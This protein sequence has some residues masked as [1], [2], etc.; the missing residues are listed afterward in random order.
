MA[1]DMDIV[2]LNF[3]TI[4]EQLTNSGLDLPVN[5]VTQMLECVQP[6][7]HI[8]DFERFT[9]RVAIRASSKDSSSSTGVSGSEFEKIFQRYLVERP[10]ASSVI[11]S[12]SKDGYSLGGV[13]ESGCVK[14]VQRCVIRRSVASSATLT[15]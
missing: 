2:T 8:E 5:H 6:F 12:G 1:S 13:R 9:L 4:N 14:I 11:L 3:L 7:N 10:A 15:R